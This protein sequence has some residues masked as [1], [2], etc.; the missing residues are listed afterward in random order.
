MKRAL[1]YLMGAAM[2]AV[3]VL[4]FVNPAP[5]IRIVPP[6]LPA[7]ALL[8]AVSGAAEILLGLGV[9]VEKTR[10]LAAYGLIALFIAVFPANIYMAVEQ[11]QLSPGDALPVW[12]MWAR[13]P[14]QFLFIALAW[15]LSKAR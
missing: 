6:F 12:A 13:L 8:V 11:V 4:H 7:P 15:R 2:V 9:M 14:L 5:F 10:R 1:P 3:G